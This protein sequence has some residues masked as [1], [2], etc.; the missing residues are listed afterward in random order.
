MWPCSRC[1]H[2]QCTSLGS[3]HSAI[4]GNRTTTSRACALL[5]NGAARSEGHAL[6][7]NCSHV[8][9]PAVTPITLPDNNSQGNGRQQVHCRVFLRLQVSSWQ[10]AGVCAVMLFLRWF[11]MFLVSLHLDFSLVWLPHARRVED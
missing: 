10:D 3:Y 4:D 9:Q 1:L 11:L 6:L 5:G 7:A 8:L 2:V